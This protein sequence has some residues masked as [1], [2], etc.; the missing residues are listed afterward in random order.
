MVRKKEEIATAHAELAKKIGLNEIQTEAL[1][2][3]KA[4]LI[5]Q[6]GPLEQEWN[7]RQELDKAA[8]PEPKLVELTPDA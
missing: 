5:A 1:K 3:Q 8:S 6:V 7:M 4:Q 2:L